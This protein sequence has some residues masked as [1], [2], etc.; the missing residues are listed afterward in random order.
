MDGRWPPHPKIYQINTIPWL[1]EIGTKKKQLLTLTDITIDMLPAEFQYFDVIYLLGIWKR[2]P[3]GV[4]ISQNN[5]PLHDECRRVLPD[6]Q[7][8]DLIG[9]AF[10]I[11]NY[12]VNPEIGG[13]EGLRHLRTIL[14]KLNLRLIVDF[15]PNHFGIDAPIAQSHPDW[16]IQGTYDELKH[17]PESFVESGSYIFA[18]A[19]DPY[20]PPWIDTIQINAFSPGLRTEY[21]K[22][23]QYIGEFCDGVR[24][25][26][27]MLQINAVFEK[28][29]GP[30]VGCAPTTEF[31]T[32]IIQS[33]KEKFPEFQFIAEV[34]WDKEA[35]LHSFGFDY[36]Y[37]KTYYDKLLVCSA[38]NIRHYLHAD[39]EYQKKL[40]RFIENHDEPRSLTQFGIHR[41]KTAAVL[42]LFSP[43][44][45]LFYEGQIQG[46]LL[47]TP[48]Q[49]K[50]RQN[51]AKIPEI[52]QFYHILLNFCTNLTKDNALWELI[53]MHD[54]QT[55]ISDFPL[56]NEDQIIE[57]DSSNVMGMLWS[58]ESSFKFAIVNYSSKQSYAS[59]ELDTH[60]D[61]KNA[62]YIQIP[63]LK[64]DLQFG[65]AHDLIQKYHINLQPWEIVLIEGLKQK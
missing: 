40:V 62:T 17:S 60:L 26:M 11:F 5:K 28:I 32:E 56:R 51:E 53:T 27:A 23:L 47:R 52:E 10:S 33:V 35:I 65:F 54:P 21:K 37:D 29:W 19:R 18:H 48:V 50:R 4:V 12:E 1:I 30:K 63:S 16:F 46:L 20:F 36:C 55:R 14:E 34:Y 61:M 39:L 41:A 24:C 42:T 57:N 59:F 7:T 6:L 15:I 44:A 25:D 3:R 31:W 43:G 2:S 8:D 49:L 22:I 58:G 45:K 38:P 64:V 9:S 13:E